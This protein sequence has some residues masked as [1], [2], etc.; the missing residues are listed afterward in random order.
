[1][2]IMRSIAT[3]TLVFFVGYWLAGGFDYG[4]RKENQGERIS[5]LEM[6]SRAYESRIS[7]LEEKIEMMKEGRR[8]MYGR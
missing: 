3:H 5:Q 8:E 4:P 6:S 2:K 7:E 1:M